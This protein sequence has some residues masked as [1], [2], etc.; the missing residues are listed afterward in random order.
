MRLMDWILSAPKEA[1]V[2]HP[3]RSDFVNV[4]M[5]WLS[6]LQSFPPQ[7]LKS[8]MWMSASCRGMSPALAHEARMERVERRVAVCMLTGEI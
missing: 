5:P 3:V 4:H 1:K 7:V 8:A 2:L 6:T